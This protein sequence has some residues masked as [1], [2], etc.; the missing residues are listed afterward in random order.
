MRISATELR[1]NLYRIIDR[2]LETGEAVEIVR[3][4]GTVRLIAD[5]LPGMWDL[6]E[7]QEA[8]VGDPEDI[9]SIDWSTR[10]RGAEELNDSLP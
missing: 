8:V 6:L 3:K 9:V 2:V 7:V 10:W 5:R 1:Q 4:G